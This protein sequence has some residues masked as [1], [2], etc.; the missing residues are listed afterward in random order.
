MEYVNQLLDS[1]TPL[2]FAVMALILFLVW[3]L[4]AIV[5]LF[6]NRKHVKLIAVACVP[7]GLSVIAWSGLM[8]WAVT[9]NML[10]QFNKQEKAAK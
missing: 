9:G 4:P 2:Q 1:A 5:A 6:F 10:K 8:V 3:F 7:A